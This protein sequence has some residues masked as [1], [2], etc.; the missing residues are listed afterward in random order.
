[1]ESGFGEKTIRL[2]GSRPMKIAAR[3]GYWIVLECHEALQ[4]ASERN[5][6]ATMERWRLHFESLQKK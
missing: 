4:E 6:E 3:A 5:L 2:R 1:M